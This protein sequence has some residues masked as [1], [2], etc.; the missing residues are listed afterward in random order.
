MCHD[1]KLYIK[2]RSNKHYT[3][4]WNDADNINII[5]HT[6]RNKAQNDMLKYR[7]AS[8]VEA[9]ENSRKLDNSSLKVYMENKLTHKLFIDTFE[10][11]IHI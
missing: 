4:L 11:L 1:N 7:N 8:S 6:L 3:K 5:R 10:S 9:Y 2:I